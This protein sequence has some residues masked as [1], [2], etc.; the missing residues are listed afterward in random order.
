MFNEI[1]VNAIFV[2]DQDQALDFYVGKLGFE[3]GSDVRNGPFRWLTVKVPGDSGTELQLLQ[4]GPPIHDEA[5]TRQ[6]RELVTKGALG[7]LVL[8]TS[9]CRKTA[10]TL[11]SRGVEFTQE[12][13][14][15]FYGIDCGIRDPFGNQIRILQQ[16]KV[17]AGT[18][19][20]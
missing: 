8:K 20:G 4:P 19:T 16:G 6:I 14:E 12:A 5:T 17:P 7:S 10:E 11:K 3:K 18:T 15:H 13:T 9:D 1:S 2:L